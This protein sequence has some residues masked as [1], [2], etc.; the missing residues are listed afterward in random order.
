MSTKSKIALIFFIIPILAIA[1]LGKV[2]GIK[3][4]DTIVLLIDGNKQLVI[5]VADIDC[6]ERSQAYGQKARKFTSDAIFG[7]IVKYDVKKKDRYGRSI[8]FLFYEGKNLSHEL[9]KAGLAW[10]YSYYSDDRYMAQLEAQARK[11][12]KG[13]WAD[14][15]PINP[16]EYRKRQ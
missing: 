16:Y 2:V 3:D 11:E 5:R 15:H 1:Q 7:K 6:P 9:L 12:K 14:S 10:H 4:G 13:L 8:A